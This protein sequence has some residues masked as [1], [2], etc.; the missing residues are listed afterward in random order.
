MG[1][2]RGKYPW[3]RRAASNCSRERFPREQIF[4][5]SSR[6][7]RPS[8]N[9]T[10]NL[11][12]V[13]QSVSYR[14]I[15][16][17]DKVYSCPRLHDSPWAH[18]SSPFSLRSETSRRQHEIRHSNTLENGRWS[19]GLKLNVCVQVHPRL[20][21]THASRFLL[22]YGI[23]LPLIRSETIRKRYNKIYNIIDKKR[24]LTVNVND[25][26]IT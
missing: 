7:C 18:F 20:A 6:E 12:T 25:N 13:R 19:E 2:H 23:Y 22:H 14:V 15:I 1:K 10:F 9:T 17:V 3:R 24:V 5:N 26:R 21:L 11:G 16:R 8:E 4:G